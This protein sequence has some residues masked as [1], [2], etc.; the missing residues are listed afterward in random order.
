MLR[1]VFKNIEGSPDI[2]ESIIQDKKIQ[3]KDLI[4]TLPQEYIEDRAFLEK[5]FPKE[6]IESA[7]KQ[8]KTLQ[9]KVSKIVK[10]IE[11]YGSGKL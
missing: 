1:K 2:I 4:K 5:Y 3:P 9:S 7:Q 10:E 6:L 8:I 11:K